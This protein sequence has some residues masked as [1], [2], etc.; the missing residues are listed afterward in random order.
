MFTHASHSHRRG[1]S[2]AATVLSLFAMLVLCAMISLPAQ[3]AWQLDPSHS[4]LEATVIELTPQGPVPHQ[5]RVREL[6][7]SIGE[8]G[9]LRLPLRL[10]QTDVL[11]RLGGLPVWLKGMTEL[12]LATLVTQLP[13]ERLNNLAV[14]DS[15]TETLSFRVDAEGVNRQE[16]LALRF[17]RESASRIRIST[18][19][20]VAVDGRELMANPTLRTVI[21][22]LGYEQIG[23]EVPVTLDATLIER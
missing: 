13:P 19:E 15:L 4:A 3:A 1:L 22:L 9:T 11:E 17:T 2:A 16:P 23:D 6:S 21:L 12:P 10:S 20:R 5:H 8:D 14:G 7:G 18:A